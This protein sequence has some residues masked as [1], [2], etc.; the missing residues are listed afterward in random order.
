MI[1]TAKNATP[2]VKIRLYTKNDEARFFQ[3]AELGMLDLAIDLGHGLF[4]AHGQHGVTQADQ[5]A[6]QADC[7]GQRCVRNQPAASA[8][9]ASTTDSREAATAEGARLAPRACSRTRRSSMT[10]I[11]VVTYMMR[12]AFSLD[13]WMPLMFSHQK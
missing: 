9:R 7:V 10:T 11:T 2:A 3:V 13:S 8:S 4:A 6:D 5:N 12:R 1:M